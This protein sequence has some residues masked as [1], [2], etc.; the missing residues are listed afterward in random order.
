MWV[1]IAALPLVFF[2]RG[3]R[4]KARDQEMAASVE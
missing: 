3:G 1:T 2:L 4:R